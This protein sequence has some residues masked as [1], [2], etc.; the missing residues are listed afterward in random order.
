MPEQR[1]A[2]NER[3]GAASASALEA[4][5]ASS[6]AG[7]ATPASG[8]KR[9]RRFAPLLLIVVLMVTVYL[10]GGHEM[11]SLST[12]IRQREALTGLVGEHLLLASLA[13]VIVYVVAVALSFPGASLLTVMGGFLF[14]WLVGGGLTALAAT[15]GAALIFLAARTSLGSALRG[16]AGPFI[17]RMAEGFRQD[18]FNYLLFLRLAPIFPFWL[19]NIA[20]ALFDM[21]LRPYLAATFIG[22]LPGTFA[23]AFIGTGLD[24]VIAAQEAADPGCAAAGT[25]RIDLS[26]LVTG[27]LVAAFIALALAALLPVLLKRLRARGS[28]RS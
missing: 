6:G 24:S 17:A 19:V 4:E 9:F 11:L 16:Q 22:I 1:Q 21:R 7:K 2:G 13:Y 18:A 26:A 20:P 27:E 3:K 5:T 23:Y 15:L 25:C 12:L 10:S 28:A 8:A 14:G